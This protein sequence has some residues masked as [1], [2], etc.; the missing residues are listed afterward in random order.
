MGWYENDGSGGFSSRRDIEADS[1]DA[2]AVQGADLDGDGDLDV[3]AASF[4]NNR[5][6]WYENDGEGAF[7]V[8]RV[9]AVGG[10]GPFD[11][12]AADL[13]GDGDLDVLSA[14]LGD[15][16]VEWFENQ[17]GGSF[18]TQPEIWSGADQL[19]SVFAADLDGDGDL[20]V[21]AA[22]LGDATVAWYENLATPSTPAAA[23]I[24]APGNVSVR[25][26]GSYISVSWD[27]LGTWAN[28]GSAVVRYVATAT[29]DDDEPSANCETEPPSTACAIENLRTGVT[30]AVVVHVEN[31]LGQGPASVPV[32]ATTAESFS[33][34]SVI[35]SD[36][37]N[38]LAV[39]AVDLDGDGDA[40][41][42]STSNS[43]DKIAWYETPETGRFPLSVSSR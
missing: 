40:D 43:E 22:I 41:L 13:D 7:P 11:I 23:P 10:R 5:V 29:P 2:Y 37:G 19:S 6:A 35:S 33:A 21:L 38:P 12:Q 8:R 31:A 4:D 36:A 3:L 25:A 14:F 26:G 34:Q 15:G 24:A 30:Y 17:G 9:I 39:Q 20:D 32:E 1:G 28:G 42:L 27:T 18:S 16:S